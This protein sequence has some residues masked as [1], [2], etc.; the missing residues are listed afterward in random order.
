MPKSEPRASDTLKGS[1][2]RLTFVNP[3]NGYFVAKVDVPGLGERTVTGFTPDIHVGEE[4][5]AR[6]T[7]TKS[8]WGTQFKAAHV[9]LA[10]PN[11]A[12]GKERYLAQ[13]IKGIGPG[14]AKKLIEAFGENVFH[15]IEHEPERLA[16]VKGIG[17]KRAEAIV[18]AYAEKKNTREVEV[19]LHGLGLGAGRVTKIHKQ[20]GESAVAAIKENPYILCDPR[21]GVWGI[22]FLMADR[23]AAKLRVAPN[24]EHRGRAGIG[25][26]LNM[27]TAQGS[28]GLPVEDVLVR[29]SELLGVDHTLLERCIEQEVL[30]EN[31]VRDF[32]DGKPCLFPRNVFNAEQALATHVANLVRRVPARPIRD[33]E[34]R[35][36]EAELDLGIELTASQK[37]A[38]RVALSS[39]VC[40]MTGGPGTGKTTITKLILKVLEDST[41][42]AVGGHGVRPSIVLAAPTGKAAKRASEATGRPA[43]TVHRILEVQKDGKFKHNA[44]NPLDGDI[45]VADEFSMA[46]VFLANSYIQAV[47]A[48]GRLLIVGDVDQLPSVGPGKVLADLIDSGVL[49]VVRL[50][51]VRRQGAGSAII[52]NAHAVNNGGLPRIGYVKGSDFQ[53]YPIEPKNR[54]DEEEKR[55]AREDIAREVVRVCKDSYLLGFDPIEDV[56]VLAPMKKGVL[57]IEALNQALQAALNPLPAYTVELTGNKW[58][59]GDK[60]MQMRNNY[61]KGV[62]NGDV[63]IIKEIDTVSKTLSVDYAEKVCMYGFHEVDELNLAYAMTVHR[64][65]GSEFSMVVMPLDMSHYMMLKRN[66]LFTGI[67]RAKK[68]FVGYGSKQALRQAVENSNEEPRYSRLRDLLRMQVLRQHEPAYRMLQAADREVQC[69]GEAL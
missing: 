35:I 20:F 14:N 33:L 46:D 68:L 31:L 38:A 53:F 41:D 67:T 48:H 19:F 13:A 23:V 3:E 58:C 10:L 60:V 43:S 37:E 59:T 55:A 52:S 56:Q 64:S 34:A 11:A 49:P 16:N 30:A 1:V 18:Q 7:W 8:N 2:L 57:G 65:Q 24:S 12:D 27:A 32:V 69:A 6:G 22:G 50:T 42:I 21:V 47:P 17:P 40:V 39:N 62:F 51:E 29:A 26:V 36:L 63:G 66:L 44:D 9:A 45:F 4:I 25:H 61:D 15:V 5:T 54:D 28:C